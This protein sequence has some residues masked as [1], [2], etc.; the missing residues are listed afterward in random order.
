MNVWVV[1]LVGCIE[2]GVPSG[3]FGVFDSKELATMYYDEMRQSHD[4]WDR[5]G[6]EGYWYIEEMTINA[7]NNQGWPFGDEEE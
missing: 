2:C 6:G 5:F 4:S 3:I 7:L 1:G